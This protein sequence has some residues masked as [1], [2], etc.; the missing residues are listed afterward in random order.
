ME[1]LVSR[2]AHT[3]LKVIDFPRYN[4]KFSGE[5]V[6]LRGIVYVV[7]RFPLHFMFYRRNLDHFSKSAYC[8]C[9]F[10][11]LK[12]LEILKILKLQFLTKKDV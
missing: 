9:N 10:F 12:W 5:N 6:I 1:A 2:I 11:C 7:S 4:M 8:E 3:V